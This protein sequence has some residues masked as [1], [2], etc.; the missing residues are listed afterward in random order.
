MYP[1]PA[2]M[3]KLMFWLVERLPK[4][5]NEDDDD[6]EVTGDVL[7][8][9]RINNALVAW[10]NKR[11]DPVQARNTQ[12]RTSTLFRTVP[13]SLSARSNDSEDA[14]LYQ[15]TTQPLAHNQPLDATRVL[16]SLQNAHSHQ[17]ARQVTREQDWEALNKDPEVSEAGAQTTMLRACMCEWGFGCSHYSTISAL[18]RILVIQSA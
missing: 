15:R 3:R 4:T 12:P 17:M 7:S 1:N 2:E 11:F 10:F 16:P 6:L 13:I 9:R 18:I 8:Q 14:A 5:E